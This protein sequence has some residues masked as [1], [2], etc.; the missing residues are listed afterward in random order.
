M[1]VLITVILAVTLVVSGVPVLVVVM[2][3]VLV[4]SCHF[5]PTPSMMTD[6]GQPDPFSASVSFLS[7]KNRGLGQVIP[8]GSLHF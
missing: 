6:A 4:V 7:N 3:R 2:G 1:V 5:S 8:K